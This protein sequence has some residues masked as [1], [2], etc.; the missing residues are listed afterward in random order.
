M[1][2]K[3]TIEGGYIH[4]SDEIFFSSDEEES[5]QKRA[6]KVFDSIAKNRKPLMSLNSRQSINTN[7]V[8]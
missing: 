1:A 6:S 8:S 4:D 3:F 2:K 7:Y 5:N